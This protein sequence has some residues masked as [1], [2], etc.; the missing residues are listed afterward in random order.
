MSESREDRV[1]AARK[2]L[3]HH[4]RLLKGGILPYEVDELAEEVVDALF[5]PEPEKPKGFPFDRAHGSLYDRGAADSYYRRPRSPHYGGVGG[6][7][8]PRVEVDD[9]ASWH[10]YNQGYEDNERD[11][12]HG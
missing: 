9:P 8:G 10:E 6:A 1:E 3:W 12:N 4:V 11:G 5:P 7:S 2:A